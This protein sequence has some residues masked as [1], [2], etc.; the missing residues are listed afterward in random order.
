VQPCWDT[1]IENGN[2]ELSIPIEHLI[3][4]DWVEGKAIKPYMNF[5]LKI[6]VASEDRKF[7]QI[8]L[9]SDR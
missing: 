4:H 6:V 2:G 3:H 8:Q 7:P 5:K 1:E 9:L